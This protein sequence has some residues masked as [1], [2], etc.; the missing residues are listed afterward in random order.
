MRISIKDTAVTISSQGALGEPYLELYPGVAP[1]PLP[2]GEPI[3]GVDSPR[4]DVVSTKLAN[5]LEAAS[6]VLEN[7]PDALAHFVTGISGLTH[8]VDG[9]I[10]ENRSDLRQI[11]TE[12]SQTVK[13]LRAL[14]AVAKT[15]FEPGGKT[16]ALI[17]DASATIKQLRTDVPVISKEAQVALGGVA[18]LTGG[19]TEEDGK[20]LKEAIGRYSA[21]GEKLDAIALR[22]D[23]MLAKLEAGAGTLGATLKDKQVYDDL[24]SLLS[25]LKKHPWKMLWKD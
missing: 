25:D 10:T 7:D 23:R 22:A 5:F 20:K 8:T 3:R 14:S 21:A 15:Q 6:K 18:A 4:I 2:A 1:E 13:D 17:D 12:L 16:S 11:I 24:R 9:V 19:F